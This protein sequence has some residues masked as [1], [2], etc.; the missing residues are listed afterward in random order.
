MNTNL[1][2]KFFGLS[3][4]TLSIGEENRPQVVCL[5]M[6]D[7]VEQEIEEG[8]VVCFSFSFFY[9]WQISGLQGE[10]YTL[11][12]EEEGCATNQVDFK[13]NV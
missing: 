7:V 10:F 1:H 13:R 11:E 9:P 6:T 8:G 5:D 4:D 2:D 3:L 12:M